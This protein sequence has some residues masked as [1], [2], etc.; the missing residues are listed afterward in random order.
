MMTIRSEDVFFA[1]RASPTLFAI[2]S[3]VR[4]S[5]IVVGLAL[6]TFSVFPVLVVVALLV[7]RSYPAEYSMMDS[8]HWTWVDIDADIGVEA[9]TLRFR[10]RV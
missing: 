4:L 6:V 3:T 10:F 7:P 1:V 5:D 2:V 9:A 8:L